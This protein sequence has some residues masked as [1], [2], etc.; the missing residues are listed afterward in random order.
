MSAA[1]F[2]GADLAA[3]MVT[4]L[5]DEQAAAILGRLS[6]TELEML[7]E[8]MCALGEIEPDAIIRSI[9]SFAERTS[10]PGLPAEP[11]EGRV[12]ALMAQAIGTVKAE[13]VM[14]RIAP[15]QQPGSFSSLEIVKWLSPQALIRLVDG[16]HP[17]AIALLLVQIDPEVA[18]QVLH[19][20]P[21]EIQPGVVHRIATMA[22]VST[23]ALAMLEELVARKLK[24]PQLGDAIAMGGPRDAANIINSSGKA[25]EKR[26]MPDIQKRDRALAKTIEDELFKFEHLFVLDPQSMGALLREVESDVLIDAL[27]GISEPDREVFFRAMSSRAAD[28]VR[29]EIGERGRLKLAD[30]ISAQKQV[31]AVAKRLAAEGT[32]S[33]GSEEADYV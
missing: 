28:G 33:M 15:D 6:A 18:A 3:V 27:K 29:D 11:R 21:Q 30:V 16:E 9:A 12:R 17:Q 31:V 20:L 8:R 10:R 19:A 26:V 4:L 25:M 5:N 24:Q 14:Q 32:I 2:G 23:D 7:G 1:A 13:S 22:P